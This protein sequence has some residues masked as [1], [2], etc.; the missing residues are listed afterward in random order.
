MEVAMLKA[1]ILAVHK[2]YCADS[3]YKAEGWN[4]A[5]AR[6]QEVTAFPITVKHVKSKHDYYK[7]DWKVWKELCG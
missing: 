5:L 1:L 7:K 2:G 4:M 3:S 6:V